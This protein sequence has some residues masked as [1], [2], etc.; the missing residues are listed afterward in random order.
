MNEQILG[1]FWEKVVMPLVMTALSVGFSPR[2]VN[3][4]NSH[5][6]IANGQFIMI[7]RAVYNTTGGHERS[8]TR[9]SKIK[10]SPSRSNGT[11]IDSSSPMD[12][13]HPHTHVYRP[14]VHVGRLTKNIYLGLNGHPAMLLLGAFE[15]AGTNSGSVPSTLDIAW[16]QL[17]VQRGKWLQEQSS[18]NLCWY[19]AGYF[20][21]AQKPRAV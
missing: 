4:P 15:H 9:S 7:R 5:D 2:K 12:E 8:K 13:S 10:P 11:G 14:A 16:N 17:A 21:S 20:T 18:F 3:D 1:S 19:G 6:A